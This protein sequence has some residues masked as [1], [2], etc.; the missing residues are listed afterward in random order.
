MYLLEQDSERSNTILTVFSDVPW[1]CT[2]HDHCTISRPELELK[3]EF[4]RLEAKIILYIPE[5][6]CHVMGCIG[7]YANCYRNGTYIYII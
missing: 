5:M 3:Y 6:S 1:L 4:T 2:T 7:I